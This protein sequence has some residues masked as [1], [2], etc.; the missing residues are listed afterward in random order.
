MRKISDGWLRYRTGKRRDDKYRSGVHPVQKAIADSAPWN[1]VSHLLLIVTAQPER[2]QTESI[3]SL[4]PLR[5][6]FS[7]T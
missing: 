3:A 4:S 2:L 7:S 5:N 6:G 1:K